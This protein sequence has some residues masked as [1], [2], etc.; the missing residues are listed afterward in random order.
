M[1]ASIGFDWGANPIWKTIASRQRC[2]R[3]AGRNSAV[4]NT[5][6][7]LDLKL[8]PNVLASNEEFFPA[9]IY[10]PEASV[11]YDIVTKRILQRACEEKRATVEADLWL[12]HK[13]Y[14]VSC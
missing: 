2:S 4:R 5:T 1:P 12:N 7:T 6:G 3:S 10:Q 14:F 8:L 11:G 9:C 13:L